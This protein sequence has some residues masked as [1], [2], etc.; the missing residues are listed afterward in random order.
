MFVF[1]DDAGI[2]CVSGG[3]ADFDAVVGVVFGRVGV[4]DAG[5]FLLG[6]GGVGVAE[7]GVSA[8]GGGDELDFHLCDE[9]FEFGMDSGGLEGAPAGCVDGGLLGAGG[10]EV[11]GAGGAVAAVFLVVSAAGVSEAVKK[12]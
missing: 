11:R 8:G 9:F 1:G 10:G 2:V 4:A 6:S 12:H 7:A 3:E 5:G